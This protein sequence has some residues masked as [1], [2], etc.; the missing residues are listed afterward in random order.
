MSYDQVKAGDH[1]S[2]TTVSGHTVSGEVLD[3]S[4]AGVTLRYQEPTAWNDSTLVVSEATIPWKN[5]K[6]RFKLS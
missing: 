6:R 2:I 1:C 3:V 4:K 5:Q